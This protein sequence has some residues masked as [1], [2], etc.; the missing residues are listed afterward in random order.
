MERSFKEEVEKLKLGE[1]ETLQT[2]VG[3]K[4]PPYFN[5]SFT[6]NQ[7]FARLPQGNFTARILSTTV[8]YSTSPRLT[9]SNLIQYD[10][11]SRNMGW[12]SVSS[13]ATGWLRRQ[14][15]G[16]TSRARSTS[17]RSRKRSPRCA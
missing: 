14:R 10:N 16:S 1:G 8:S 15:E 4:L 2:T 12:R 11:R 5:I 9:L 3:Y 17:L 7:T 6:T 13:A